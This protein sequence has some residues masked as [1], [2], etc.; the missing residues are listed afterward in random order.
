MNS[1]LPYMAVITPMSLTL[2]ARPA[3][4]R[5]SSSGLPNSFTSIAPAETLKRSVMVLPIS[6]SSCIDSLRSVQAAADQPGGI[7][8]S[9]S[10]TRATTVTSHDSDSIAM[11]TRSRVRALDTTPDSVEVRACCA[12]MT[13]LLS[14]LTSEPVWARVKN[15]I[16][17]R[18]TCPNTWVR[19]S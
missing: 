16:G 13:S 1:V 8:N 9:G 14:L 4:T 7:T 6:A 11:S 5:A 2:A 12:P 17:C 3:K 15:A 18:C 19:R 10:S